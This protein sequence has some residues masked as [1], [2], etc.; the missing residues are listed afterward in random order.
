MTNLRALHFYSTPEHDCSYLEGRHAKTLFVDP[1]AIIATDTY[2]Q[3]SDLGFRRSGKH[4]YRPHCD[5]CQACISIRIPVDRFSMTKSQKRVVSRNRDLKVNVKEP[6]FSDR[7]YDLYSRYINARHSDG[8]MHPPTEDQFCSFLIDGNQNS[9]FY[10]FW[11]QDQLVAVA[12]TDQL[13][14]GLSAIYTF[15]DPA[16]TKRSLG[17]YAILYQI[18]EARDLNLDYIYLGYW[19]RD[20]RKMNYKIS[21]R[22]LEMLLDGHWV[23]LK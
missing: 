8:D 21:Y 15:F 22:P 13:E 5:N 3:L 1:Q 16:L 11:D 18:A 17:T 23:L 6:Y 14:S 9:L 12:V 20:C 2:S 7:H 4:I 19:V 10:E